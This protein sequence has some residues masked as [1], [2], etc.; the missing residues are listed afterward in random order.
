M[1]IQHETIQ[2]RA[3]ELWIDGGCVD[4]RADE[5]WLRAERELNHLVKAAPAEANENDAKSRKTTGRRR[6]PGKRAA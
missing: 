4:G 3:Y 2:K 5:H 1:N 6:A